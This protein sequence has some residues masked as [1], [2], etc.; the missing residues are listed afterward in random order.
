MNDDIANDFGQEVMIAARDYTI[1]NIEML[2]AGKSKSKRGQ[3]FD[4]IMKLP[5]KILILIKHLMVDVVDDT[6]HNLFVK[7][8]DSCGKYKIVA[9]NGNDETIDLVETSEGLNYE[10]F[11]FIDEFS[12]YNQAFEINIANEDIFGEN[13][14]L[15]KEQDD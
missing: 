1:C 10:Y 11:G 9:E 3:T 13:W 6:I 5:P 4:P 14:T 7:F 15:E 8:N 12:K 2:F